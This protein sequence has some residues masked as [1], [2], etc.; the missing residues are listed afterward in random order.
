MDSAK[1]APS[2]FFSQMNGYTFSIGDRV[3]FYD[4]ES[5]EKNP[6]AV[7]S[8]S[9]YLSDAFNF[10]VTTFADGNHG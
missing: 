5:R 9:K 8:F 10:E 7:M 4:V 2:Y 6:A 3:S 1:V